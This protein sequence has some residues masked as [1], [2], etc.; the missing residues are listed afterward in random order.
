[1]TSPE[2]TS[3]GVSGGEFKSVP[4][5]ASEKDTVKANHE[6]HDINVDDEPKPHLH[7]VTFM[8]VFA[9]CLIYFAQ[10]ACIVGAGAVS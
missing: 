4:P 9:V 7:A 1:M 8:A 3:P 6:E 2:L 10:N 5:L